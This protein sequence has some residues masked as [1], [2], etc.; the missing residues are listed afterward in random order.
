MV[1]WLVLEVKMNAFLFAEP[2][3]VMQVRLSILHTVNPFRIRFRSEMKMADIS[4]DSMLLQY[5]CND[6]LDRHLLEDAVIDA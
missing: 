1:V 3:Q 4:E 2:L 6:L 5:L